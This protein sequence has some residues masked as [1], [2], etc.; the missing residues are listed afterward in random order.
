MDGCSKREGATDGLSKACDGL[1]EILVELGASVGMPFRSCV[2]TAASGEAVGDRVDAP[3][4]LE[5]TA[6]G[7]S[8][9]PSTS[10]RDITV[11]TPDPSAKRKR[12]CSMILRFLL[13][14][15]DS[16]MHGIV[17]VVCGVSTS[18]GLA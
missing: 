5:A 13:Q 10:T 9:D 11:A 1:G 7:D 2:G 3:T 8:S 6:L 14:A 18:E 16:L 15:D 4:T 17:V 12:P